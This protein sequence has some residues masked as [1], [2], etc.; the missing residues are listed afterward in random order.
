MDVTNNANA[1]PALS[2]SNDHPEVPN[3]EEIYHR[4]N[5]D[6][7]ENENENE[8]NSTMTFG[9]RVKRAITILACVAPISRSRRSNR[10][11]W[12]RTV[13]VKRKRYLKKHL[14]IKE[15]KKNGAMAES[16]SRDK[17]S[18]A[19][20]K[21]FGN[22]IYP[23]S[24]HPSHNQ[25]SDESSATDGDD[26]IS[27]P[28][29]SSRDVGADMNMHEPEKDS[30]SD[31]VQIMSVSCQVDKSVVGP[32]EPSLR[33]IDCSHEC[34]ICLSNFKVGE[35]VCW[36]K[37]NSCSHGFHLDCML[38]WLQ[39]HANCPLCRRRY[40]VPIEDEEDQQPST[41]RSPPF[42]FLRQRR[43]SR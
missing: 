18:A 34:P 29:P 4:T 26:F 7:D 1:S 38:A 23:K 24:N 40:L 9:E 8:N 32:E 15:V 31:C 39:N 41:T 36:S 6:E 37:G 35:K 17:R 13:K 16:Q 33:M 10:N 12:Q 27:S 21:R 30:S 19:L 5:E 2:P 22:S 20:K 14:I 43:G 3:L 25:D 28:E 42:R 11:R